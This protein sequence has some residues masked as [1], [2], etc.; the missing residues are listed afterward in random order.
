MN[1]HNAKQL[2]N[3]TLINLY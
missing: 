2:T 1:H 3:E